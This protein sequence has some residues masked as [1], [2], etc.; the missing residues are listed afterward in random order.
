MINNVLAD[1]ETLMRTWL[2]Q[3]DDASFRSAI[4]AIQAE[5][6]RRGLDDWQDAIMLAG[7]V[8]HD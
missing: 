7:V 1:P 8:P 2:W 3:C 5:A 4:A 6:E